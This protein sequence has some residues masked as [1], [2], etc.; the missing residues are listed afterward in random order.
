MKNLYILNIFIYLQGY[1]TNG[2]D[3]QNEASITNKTMTIKHNYQNNSYRYS[4]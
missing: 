1:Y 3:I 2:E 4:L